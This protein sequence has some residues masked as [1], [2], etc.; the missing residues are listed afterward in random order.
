MVTQSAE[1]NSMNLSNLTEH[2]SLQKVQCIPCKAAKENCTEGNQRQHCSIVSPDN[3]HQPETYKQR[4][5]SKNRKKEI[6]A[7][8]NSF[9]CFLSKVYSHVVAGCSIGC[10]NQCKKHKESKREQCEWQGLN[11]TGKN[12]VTGCMTNSSFSTPSNKNHSKCLKGIKICR[13]ICIG[14]NQIKQRKYNSTCKNE[15]DSVEQNFFYQ[16]ANKLHLYKLQKKP[17]GYSLQ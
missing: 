2:V 7:F 11:G 16:E 9:I 6:K 17:K 14:R 8:F 12:D 10:T 15:K 3:I 13:G 5:S 4:N 1:Q